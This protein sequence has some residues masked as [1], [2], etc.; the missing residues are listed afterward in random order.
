MAVDLNGAARGDGVVDFESVELAEG[1]DES[2]ESMMEIVLSNTQ[3]SRSVWC[4][5]ILGDCF[6]G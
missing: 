2:S 1:V 5:L 6:M 3:M 4:F